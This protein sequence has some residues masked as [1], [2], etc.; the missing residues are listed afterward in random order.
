MFV[1]ML[2]LGAA[3]LAPSPHVCAAGKRPA[4]CRAPVTTMRFRQRAI[5]FSSMKD[6]ALCISQVRKIAEAVC[7]WSAAEWELF[8]APA[9]K[10]KYDAKASEEIGGAKIEFI[11]WGGQGVDGSLGITMEAAKGMLPVDD[12]DRRQL[13]WTTVGSRR[14]EAE[15]VLK[16][17]VLEEVRTGPL[18]RVCTLAPGFYPQSKDTALKAAIAQCRLL[19]KELRELRERQDDETRDPD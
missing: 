15:D 6:E 16:R 4:Y 18:Q 9:C 11:G 8:D 14:L 10:L 19:R 13:V 12:S 1:S 17:L 5:S 2:V 7:S 3:G